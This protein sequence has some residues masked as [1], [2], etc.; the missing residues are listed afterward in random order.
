MHRLANL[1]AFHNQGRLHAFAGGNQVMMHG[2]HG[3]QGRDGRVGFVHVAVGQ[4]NVVHPVVHTLF[5]LLEEALQGPA[6]VG[7]GIGGAGGAFEE[8]GQLNRVEALVAD[9]A[10]QV[11]LRIG[12][13][14]MRQAHHL[15]VVFV[16]G[17]DTRSHASDIFEQRHDHLLADGVDGRVGHLCELL[18]EVVEETLR[19]LGQHG[20]RGI[21]TH[22]RCGLDALLAHRLYGLF[23][24]FRR[25]AE[26]ELLVQEVCLVVLNLSAAVQV[27][28]LDASGSQPLAVRMLGGQFFLDIGIVPDLAFLG[29]YQQHL[30][31]LQA[32]LALDFGGVEV[33]D[34]HLAGHHQEAPF[35]NGVPSGT[36]AVAVQDAAGV[37]AVAEQQGGGAVPGL[38]KDGMIFI[39]RAQ[40]LGD[41][42]GF[43]ETFRH[44]HGYG[45]RQAES[46]LGKEF[47]HVVQAGGIA[48]IGLYDGGQVTDIAQRPRIQHALTGL[49]P[50]PVAPHRIDFTIVAEHPEGLCQAPLREGVGGEAGMDDGHGAGEPRTGQVCVVFAQLA[51]GEHTLVHDV[52]G[53]KGTDIAVLAQPLDV[54]A[55]TV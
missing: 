32:A 29:I 2:A 50:A 47:Q 34:A 38:H 18:A 39:E 25:A 4:D 22:G 53:G 9:V 3:Q 21:V 33:Q 16:R 24:I 8:H 41:G 40:V 31:G 7:G 27:F 55:D 43:V 49:H 17:Q 42:V 14:G 37:T 35:G 20:Q 19:T 23:H 45:L 54:L 44:Q 30:S 11:Q 15:A 6:Q 52:A 48:H 26:Q 28:Q 10:Q 5:G 46:A 51:A 13:D 12:Q 36:Q 1:A